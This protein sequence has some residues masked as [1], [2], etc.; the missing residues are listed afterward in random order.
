MLL[1]SSLVVASGA[2][3]CRRDFPAWCGGGSRLKKKDQPNQKT[4]QRSP[5][6]TLL[7]KINMKI[8]SMIAVASCIGRH[9]ACQRTMTK[10]IF[11]AC[12]ALTVILLAGAVQAQPPVLHLSFDKV[13][14]TTV[15]NDGTGGSAMNGTLINNAAGSASIVSGGKFGNCLSISGSSVLAGYVVI[16]NAVV[17]LNVESGYTWTVAMWVKTTTQGGT[18]AYQGDGSWVA[19]NTT[20]FMA[21]NNGTTGVNSTSAG[22]VRW[23][24]GWEQ[25]TAVINDGN[26]HHIVFTFDGANKVQYVDGVV[27]SF[28]ADGWAVGSG[29]GGVGGQFWIGGSADT[30]DG[31]VNLNGLIDEVYVFNEALT[32]AEVT[33]LYTENTVPTVPA[34]IGTQPA[35]PQYVLAGAQ[36][37][38]TAGNIGG[39]PP[40]TY[41]WTFN[42]TDVNLLPDATNFIGATSNVLTIL[43]VT[44]SDTSSTYQL[45]IKNPVGT[46][47]STNV[48]LSIQAPA[49]VGEWFTNGTLTE[50]SG[51]QPAGT[52]NGGAVGGGNYLFTNDVPPGKTGRSL[53]LYNGDTAIEISNTATSDA[54]Y[55]STFDSPV[56]NNLTV[57]FWAKGLPSAAWDP[58]IS[59]YG[60]NSQG[61][62]FRAGSPADEPSWTVRD[63]GAGGFTLGSGSGGSLTGDLDDLHADVELDTNDWHFY[64]GTFNAGTGIR[65]L[66]RDGQ[67]EG[68]ETNNVLYFLSPASHVC[69]GA[70]DAAGTLGSAFF[71]G[72]FYDVRVYNYDIPASLVQQLYG[73]V[74]VAVTSQP[75]P[76]APFTGRMAQIQ[77]TVSG[78]LPIAYQWLFNGTNVNLLADA[79]NFSGVNSS[80]LTILRV[81]SIDAGMY[82]LLVTNAYGNAASVG[83]AVTLTPAL[84]VGQWCTNGT[85][86]DLSGYQPAGTH[87]GYGVNASG[88]TTSG[89]GFTNDVP[90]GRA[91]QSLVLNG[92]T[93][94]AISNSAT[95]DSAYTNTFDD[96]IQNALTVA[97]WAKGWPASWNPFVSK[98]GEGPGWQI[99]NDGNNNVSPCWTVRGNAGTV[100]LGTAVY[101]N[102]EDM[103]ATSLSYGTPPFYSGAWHHYAG[104]YNVSTGIRNLYVDGVLVAQETGNGLYNLDQSAHLCLGAKDTS[105]TMGNFFAGELFDV[106]VYNY[107]LSSNEIAVL[108]YQPDPS[109][110]GQ[111]PQAITAVVSETV[112][113]NATAIGTAP[114]TNQWQF[115]GTNLTDGYYDGAT[116][117]GSGTSVLTIAN[118]TT[119]L[120]GVY[121]LVVSNVK[122]TLTSSS[123]TLTVLPPQAP[124]SGIVVGQWFTN[125]SLADVSGYSPAGSHD[126]YCLDTTNFVASTNYAFANDLPGIATGKSLLL[127]GI[128]NTAAISAFIVISN[129]ANTDSNYLSTFDNTNVLSI[130]FWAKGAPSASSWTPWVGK[131]GDGGTGYQF[132]TGGAND[133]EG[134]PVPCWT[135]RDNSSGV[136]TLGGGPSWSEG[137]DQDDMH[138]AYSGVGGNL[139][140]FGVSS[141]IAGP[142]HFYVGTFDGVGGVRNL[143][144]DTVLRAQE[145]GNVPYNQS[146]DSHVCIGAEDNDGTFKNFPTG[147]EIYNVCIYNAAL[148]QAN[149]VY[150]YEQVVPSVAPVPPAPPFSGRPVL[151]GSQFVLKWATGTL[152]QATNVAGPWT[153]TLGATSPYTNT[154][155]GVPRMFFTLTN[156]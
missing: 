24:Q 79:T 109:I 144:V 58:W 32:Q 47:Y 26:W 28:T 19:N 90:F 20:L 72:E 18:W 50:L 73:P 63:G 112:T 6:I 17:P 25:G 127:T 134:N 11:K 148:S 5:P 75:Q 106:R 138:A 111:P 142:W 40:F 7:T 8:S 42:G 66:Y 10:R 99:R 135:V 38:F 59:K 115:N 89:Y 133:N 129:S 141:P 3:F 139:D 14:G 91:G 55:H 34:S 31:D 104:T 154:I 118:L 98:Y 130:S 103:A 39:N 37:Q 60:D 45:A 35:T 95:P 84:L 48:T 41:Q 117:T 105:G 81:S 86:A 97:C 56:N 131:N 87:I 23:G 147:F 68:Q 151:N 125:A 124:A 77:A 108:A 53:F 113:I 107:D 92:S 156:E 76:I 22:G 2:L 74:P 30:G 16:S 36:A 114:I 44:P 52:H 70:Q 62:Q 152:L 122:G 69:I 82:Q 143:Y 51:Y 61:W 128:S 102:G 15:T 93:G 136:Y 132:R 149:I 150:L 120:Q 145:V 123:T 110:A 78:A 121:R 83:A 49:L 94:I 43:S 80:V 153:P 21:A 71:T 88:T 46:T 33:Q 126:G 85:L 119:N 57:A 9:A 12:C 65:N 96:T 155:T 54:N 29:D 4:A 137:G 64:V 116:I 146:P 101:G 100:V 27:D 67:L 140:Y 1:P 13:G